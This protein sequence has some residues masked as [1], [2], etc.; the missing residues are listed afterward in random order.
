MFWVSAGEDT[1]ET[2]YHRCVG[3]FLLLLFLFA[4]LYLLSDFSFGFSDELSQRSAVSHAGNKRMLQ[5]DKHKEST[6]AF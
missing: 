2:M 5:T 4:I 3:L 6:S 1:D